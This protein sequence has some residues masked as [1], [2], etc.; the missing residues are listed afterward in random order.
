MLG[1]I[2]GQSRRTRRAG[3]VW[4]SPA[5]SPVALLPQSPAVPAPGGD[6]PGD[7]AVLG[8]WRRWLRAQGLSA[9]TERLY[10]VGVM[11]F[12]SE[13]DVA[14]QATTE[15]HITA[16]LEILGKH[17]QARSKYLL[18]LRSFFAYCHRRGWVE[19]N[20]TLG[21]KVRRRKPRAAA[22]LTEEELFR[23]FCAAYNRHPRRAYALL[24]SFGLGTRRME[25]AGIRPEDVQGDEVELLHCKGGKTR[26]VPL[27]D[28]ARAGLEGLRP[29]WNGTVLG[30]IGAQQL[31]EWG[32]QAARDAGLYPK[33]RG[34]TTH[35]LRATYANYL[36]R[37]GVRVEVVRDL[38]G[39]ESI[40]TTQAYSEATD[41]DERHAGVARLGRPRPMR[42]E[43]L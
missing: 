12:F 4:H 34:R 11:R 27:S 28:V 41:M 14:P 1:E 42:A 18:A 30:G 5:Q 17:S 31:T 39:H 25:L 36:R 7:F 9:N 38:L 32:K 13:I 15:D 35:I 33:V 8:R 16:F 43:S 10:T 20:P 40:A 26:R 23:I 19:V 3:R 29:W 22:A 6:Y 24:L 37:N 21:L 2:P